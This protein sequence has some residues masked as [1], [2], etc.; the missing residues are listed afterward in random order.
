MSHD[1]AI[2][3]VKQTFEDWSMYEAVVRHDYMRHQELVR[4]LSS[5]AA[6]VSG[7]LSIV[8]LGCGDAWLATNAFRGLPVESYH[9]VDLSESAVDRARDNVNM[10]GQAATV[11]QGDIAEFVAKLAAESANFIL[12][13]NSLHH[14]DAGGKAAILGHCFRSLRP[15]GVLCWIDPIRTE[16]E[17]RD[18]Y[19]TRLT[20]IMLNDWTGLSEDQRRRATQHV[21]D[22]DYPETESWMR[23]TCEQAGFSFGRRF[24]Q[25]ELFGAWT[26]LK[27]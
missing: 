3:R 22:S 9:A 6:G 17:S 25:D 14:F 21:W 7:G 1:A 2:S 24:L 26:F 12:A 5:I 27:P 23:Q 20:T 18:E 13:S 16:N 4:G 11:E 8:D 19:L 15:S 10:W